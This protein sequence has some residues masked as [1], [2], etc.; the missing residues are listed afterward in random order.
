MAALFLDPRTLP[1]IV[2]IAGTKGK[3]STAAMTEAILLNH[4]LRTLTFT[5]PHLVSVRERFRL[6]GAPISTPAWEAAFW[7]LHHST[8]TA[9]QAPPLNFFSFLTLV[10]FSLARSERVDALI[11][12]V[13]LGGLLDPT[14]VVDAEQVAVAGVATL[15]W[16]HMEVLGP[17]LPEIAAQKAGIFKRGVPA[18]VVPQRADALAVLQSAAERVGAPFAIATPAW[19]ARRCAGGTFPQLALQGDFQRTNAALAVG[20]AEVF[21]SRAPEMLRRRQRGAPVAEAF[22]GSTPAWALQEAPIAPRVLE[23]LAAVAWPGRAQKVPL[24]GFGGGLMYLDG[25][26]T[27]RS[28]RHAVAWFKRALKEAREAEPH[29]NHTLFLVFNCM[30]EKDAL[31]LLLPL[32]SVPFDAALLTPVSNLKAKALDAAVPSAEALLRGVLQRK[33]EMGDAEAVADLMGGGTAGWE[34]DVRAAWGGGE[35]GGSWQECLATLWRWAHEVPGLQ[36][37]RRRVALPMTEYGEGVTGHGEGVGGE[38]GVGGGLLPHS[39]PPTSILAG[40]EAVLQVL[41]ERAAKGAGKERLHV[42]VT[43]SLYLVGEVLARNE[44]SGAEEKK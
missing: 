32:S 17:T 1:P 28:M 20:L 3:G 11:L 18:V 22:F 24:G 14:N 19:L 8:T 21:L 23:G 25:A 38:E 37:L 5:S 43:G 33:E 29:L 40:T 36:R 16:D 44:T 30:G 2:H 13:G 6:N 7:P 15:D 35:G 4:G 31:G 9:S 27:D 10:C 12:E 42:L 39:A 26:H 34:K 41:R